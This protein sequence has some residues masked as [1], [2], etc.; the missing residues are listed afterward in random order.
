MLHDYAKMPMTRE[1]ILL[2]LAK[3]EV[4]IGYAN[5]IFFS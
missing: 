1:Q 5:L 3:K 2:D 4:N